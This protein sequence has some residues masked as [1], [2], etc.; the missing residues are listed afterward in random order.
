MGK[1]HV[2]VCVVDPGGELRDQRDRANRPL[3][4]PPYPHADTEGL[5]AWVCDALRELAAT[6]RIEALVPV[7]HGATAALVGSEWLALPVLDYEHD[8][9]PL[10]ERPPGAF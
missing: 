1:T 3:P 4:G 7:T 10:L 2:R 9:L 6:H 8:A 5:F